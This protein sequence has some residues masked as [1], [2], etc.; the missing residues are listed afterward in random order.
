M[1]NKH[2]QVE[3]NV[4]TI[5]NQIVKYKVIIEEKKHQTVVQGERAC[6]FRILWPDS[7]GEQNISN[8]KIA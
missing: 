6:L 5:F 8:G 1:T 4:S 3:R 2:R 7:D